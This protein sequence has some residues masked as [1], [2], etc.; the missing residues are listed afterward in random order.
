MSDS[1][2][3]FHNE[4]H[5]F[6]MKTDSAFVKRETHDEPSYK[7][8]LHMVH[9][10]KYRNGLSGGYGETRRQI[11]AAKFGHLSKI[12]RAGSFRNTDC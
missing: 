10:K 11:M 5:I 12:L 6:I 9:E 3:D 8:H 4:F 1:F 2:K 7:N